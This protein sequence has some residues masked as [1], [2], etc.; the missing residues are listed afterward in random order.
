MFRILK[1]SPI[2]IETLQEIGKKTFFETFA[3]SN[4]E[5]DMQQYLESNFSLQKLQGEVDNA[6]SQF[7][8][9]WD[10]TAA[11]G[12]LKVNTGLAQT[13]L[14]ENSSLEIE[15]IYVLQDYHGK[16]V[17]QLLYGHALQV[18]IELNKSSLWLGVW[19]NN[20]RAIRFYE[21]NGFVAFDTHIF[22]MGDEE[23]TDIMMRKSLSDFPD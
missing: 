23:Q 8:I 12:Y 22:K 18:A 4:S 13:E 16:K 6:G 11:I 3:D 17:G 1:V 15:R 19:E 5:S 10:G 2:E 9:A 7:F 21:K 20:P 14:Q